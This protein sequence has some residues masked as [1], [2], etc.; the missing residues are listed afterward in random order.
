M[1]K[2]V[3]TNRVFDFLPTFNFGKLWSFLGLTKP[4][5]PLTA[6][7]RSR[8]FHWVT[9]DGKAPVRPDDLMGHVYVTP[10]NKAVY[11]FG[12]SEDAGAQQAYYLRKTPEQLFVG[13][14]SAV[15]DDVRENGGV[16]SAEDRKQLLCDFYGDQKGLTLLA[17]TLG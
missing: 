11:W 15:F 8:R 1:L 3:A 10:D 9:A 6:Q 7:E 16:I 12:K 2:S 4:S 17:K 14:E 5:R 13:H